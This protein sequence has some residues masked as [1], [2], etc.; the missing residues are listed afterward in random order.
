[1]MQSRSISPKRRP[2]SRARPS[3]G[4]R[5]RICTG[6]RPR[7]WILSSTCGG[8]AQPNQAHAWSV[9]RGICTGPGPRLWILSSTCSDGRSTART[10][11]CARRLAR[12]S[13][14]MQDETA[15]LLCRLYHSSVPTAMRQ[16]QGG[17]DTA[18]AA[19]IARESPAQKI[20]ACNGQRLR[21][22]SKCNLAEH[23]K[24]AQDMM[25]GTPRH[26]DH[27]AR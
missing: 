3:T 23:Q 9:S 6:P 20:S 2:P 16:E 25:F 27:W 18:P 15:W 24:E 4:C 17:E 5:V 11:S 8:A 1:M 21:K 13:L 7:L 10:G 12:F 14:V 26:D 19:H 22:S